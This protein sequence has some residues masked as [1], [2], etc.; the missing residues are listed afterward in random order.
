MGNEYEKHRCA[1]CPLAFQHHYTDEK[2]AIEIG[3]HLIEQHFSHTVRGNDEQFRLDGYY[4]L[5]EDD[6]SR[7]LNAGA[8]SE[9]A[10]PDVAALGEDMRKMIL[11]IYAKFLSADGRVN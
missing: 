1:T 11:A 3:Q 4:R 10:P 6:E 9:C 7:A 5:L 2:H 8:L